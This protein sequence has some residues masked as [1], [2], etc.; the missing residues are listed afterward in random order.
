MGELSQG[1][2]VTREVT[3]VLSIPLKA[4]INLVI[5]LHTPDILNL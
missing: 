4:I 3:R 1:L 2:G 5:P